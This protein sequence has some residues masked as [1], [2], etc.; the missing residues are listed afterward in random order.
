MISPR[1]V[2]V[3]TLWFF[4][5]PSIQGAPVPKPP[6][7]CETGEYLYQW[8]DAGGGLQIS[9]CPPDGINGVTRIP[10]S[11]LKPTLIQPPPER[12]KSS[13]PRKK[14]RR[15]GRR[16]QRKSKPSLTAEQLRQLSSKC[17]WL[18][19][20]VQHLKGLVAE[21]KRQG[22]RKSIWQPELIRWRRELRKAHCGVRL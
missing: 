2:I 13:K 21:G 11:S 6:V 5:H 12:K 3:I 20:K 18:V 9:D 8:R 16:K 10:R 14:P 1:M 19:G 22:N 7:Y 4:V 17:R 15:G